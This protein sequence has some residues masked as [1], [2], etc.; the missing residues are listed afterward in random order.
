MNLTGKGFFLW[1]SAEC[2]DGDPERIAALVESAGLSHL[3][4]KVAD[5]DRINNDG[6]KSNQNQI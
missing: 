4:I 6:Q 3:I 5:G 2:E 1:N